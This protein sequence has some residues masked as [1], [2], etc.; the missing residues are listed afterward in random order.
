MS[1]SLYPLQRTAGTVNNSQVSILI[2]F[3]MISNFSHLSALSLSSKIMPLWNIFIQITHKLLSI[4]YY[5]FPLS[6]LVG[7]NVGFCSKDTALVI[8]LA[9]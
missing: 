2:V 3:F 6:D 9:K 7:T 1:G 5:I 8:I 4:L